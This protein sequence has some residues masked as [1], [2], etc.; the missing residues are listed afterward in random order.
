MR[1]ICLFA[2][3]DKENKIQ[4]YVVYLIKELSKI[5]DVYYMGNGAFPP[6]ELFKIA[7]Y[8]QMFYTKSHQ[9]RDFGSWLYLI[10]RLGWDKLAQYDELILCNDSIYGP[11]TDLQDIFVQMERK[12]YDFWSITSDYEYNFHLH[13][14]FMVFN[15]DVIKNEKFRNFWKSIT[16]YYNVKNC[17]YELTPLLL[18]EGFIGN[19]YVR[20]F[21]KKNILQS[22][23]EMVQNFSIPFVKV[24]NFLPQNAYTMGSG[25]SLRYKIRTLS[26][27]D[28]KLINR[29]IARNH[30]PQSFS[31]RLASWTGL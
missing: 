28:T 29:N 27:Y 2:G 26:D 11:I 10:E 6:D 31:Q 16:Y 1:R 15:N 25:L 5:S 13:R 21:H 14:Y 9:M 22:P 7:P 8:T 18:N 12:G 20:N 17:E 23:R 30:Y 19:S 3:F 24:K 4:D